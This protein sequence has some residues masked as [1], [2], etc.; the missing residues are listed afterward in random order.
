MAAHR[1][2]QSE[3]RNEEDRR[4]QR[5]GRRSRTAES[6]SRAAALVAINYSYLRASCPLLPQNGR[7]ARHHVLRGAADQ[8]RSL[9]YENDFLQW[10][11]TASWAAQERRN[12]RLQGQESV[13]EPEPRGGR[14]QTDVSTRLETLLRNEDPSPC[15]KLHKTLAEEEEMVYRS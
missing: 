10:R 6:R 14:E 9:K 3:E 8:M 7:L 4:Q 1:R 15:F 2:D 13:E 5:P 11:L 12:A